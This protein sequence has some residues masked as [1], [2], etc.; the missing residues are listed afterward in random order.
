MGI[1]DTLIRLGE[2]RGEAQTLIFGNRELCIENCR[3][4][5]ACDENLAVLR[6]EG[7]DI[8]VTGTE[9]MLENFGAYGVKLTG[10]IHSLT[11]EE[12]E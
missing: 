6:M 8:R 3:C 11:F 12:T 1:K 5:T 2:Y 9:L 7:I 4:I 10:R